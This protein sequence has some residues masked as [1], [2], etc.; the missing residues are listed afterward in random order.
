M[1]KAATPLFQLIKLLGDVDFT[2]SRRFESFI[3]H[4]FYADME[5]SCVKLYK[6]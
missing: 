3:P 1:D 6:F 2:G 4:V 5:V